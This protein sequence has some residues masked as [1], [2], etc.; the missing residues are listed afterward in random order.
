M[1]QILFAE[2]PQKKEKK[3]N[4]NL[5]TVFFVWDMWRIGVTDPI[6]AD[7]RTGMRAVIGFIRQLL[8][9]PGI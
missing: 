2:N 3:G 9:T 6:I 1:G 7:F 5:T 8:S 4:E